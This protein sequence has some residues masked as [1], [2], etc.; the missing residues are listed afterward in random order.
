MR[1]AVS[2]MRGA[3]GEAL[4]LEDRPIPEP[5][6]G[7]V[8]VRVLASGVNPS[9]VKVRAGAQG[10]LPHDEVMVH[11]DGAGIIDAVGEGVSERRLG[12]RVWLFNLNRSEDGMA[13]GVNGTAAEMIICPEDLAP[14]L[15]NGVSAE[16]GACLGVPAMTAHRAVFADGP[17]AGQVVLVTGGAGS[18]GLL[19]VQMAAA[20]GATVIATVSSG[21][22][23]ELARAAG[24][25]LIINYKTESLA[26]RIVAEF[27]SNSVDRL[28]DVD[29]GVH[30]GL[31]PQILA[32][33]GTIATYA[34]MG[35]PEPS[36]PF[37]QAMFNNTTIR[38]VFVYAM[39]D[40]AK[41][42]AIEDINTFL[43]HGVL[44]PMIAARFPFE[45]IAKAHEAVEAGGLTGN[46]VLTFS[47]E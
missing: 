18:V 36:L 11:N 12:E 22:K 35:S 14:P 15:P 17:V 20:S 34:S 29:F 38:L 4:V 1:V 7:E 30:V 47:S 43:R 6:P 37:Y 21:E 8:R 23:A 13:Q 26:D 44:A 39:P 45:D 33:N 25:A 46:V 10:A 27:G 41:W 16:E 5:G 24:A 19:A 3:A 42:S 9:D 2:R 28:V 40:E 32:R 31:T